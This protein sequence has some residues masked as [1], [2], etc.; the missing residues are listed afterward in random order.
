MNINFPDLEKLIKI[1]ERSNINSLEITDGD[2]RISIICRSDGNEGISD[3]NNNNKR[4][5]ASTSGSKQRANISAESNKNAVDD[6][7]A[8]LNKK[9][10]NEDAQNRVTAPML[11]TFYRRSEPTADEFVKVGD[12]VDRGQTLC[13]IE[14]MKMMH[15]VKAEFP[16]TI[17]E[18]LVDEGEVVEYGQPL[19]VIE[20]AS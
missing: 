17:K 12:K 4:D 1:V 16:C 6:S 20:P 14:A 19:F 2:A 13:I 5:L 3:N 15:E 10:A 7:D 8:V 11:G 18:A 9:E